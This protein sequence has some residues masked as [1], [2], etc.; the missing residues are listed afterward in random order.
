MLELLHSTLMGQNLSK[1]QD[2]KIKNRLISYLQQLIFRVLTYGGLQK[3][4]L[5]CTFWAIFGTFPFLYLI[6]KWKIA[7]F[8]RPYLSQLMS[9]SIFLNIFFILR[10]PKKNKKIFFFHPWKFF[11]KNFVFSIFLNS[12]KKSV[13]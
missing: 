8:R 12:Q 2:F 5:E 11:L 13:L 1:Q 3:K 9:H 10:F 7:D 6:N 4:N